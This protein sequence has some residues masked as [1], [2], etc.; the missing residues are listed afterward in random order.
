MEN[1]FDVNMKRSH[2]QMMVLWS[3]CRSFWGAFLQE[4]LQKTQKNLRKYAKNLK[5]LKKKFKKFENNL[6]IQIKAQKNCTYSK[7]SSIK[8]VRIFFKKLFLFCLFWL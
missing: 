2:E 6:K 8:F 3:G 5:I 4:I 7:K 1:Y